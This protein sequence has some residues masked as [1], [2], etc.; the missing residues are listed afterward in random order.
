MYQNAEKVFTLSNWC[1][2]GLS[3]EY[4]IN[5]DK[6]LGIGWGPAKNL[7]ANSDFDKEQKTILAIGQDYK[8]KGIDILL[9]AAKYLSDFKITI[10]GKDHSFKAKEYPKNVFIYDH[11]TDSA[12]ENIYLKSEFFYIFSEFDPS[13]HVL[14]E[15]Q[16]SGCVIIG[17]DAYGIS[18]A[19]VNN[20][21]GLLLK[22]REASVVAEEIRKLQTDQI[23][24]KRMQKE[25]VEN[26]QKNG[27]WVEVCNKLLQN[28]PSF[29]TKN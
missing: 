28:L 7:K 5:A 29:H 20:E 11:L 19:V 12:L 16:A 22:T 27:T 17:Y 15:A 25:A 21:S 6:I 26:Y 2:E 14:W 3:K 1:K 4:G 24:M 10:V 23:R 9:A 13:P 8:A 18:E